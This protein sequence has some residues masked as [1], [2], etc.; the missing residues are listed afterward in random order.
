MRF[1]RKWLYYGWSVFEIVFRVR[2]WPEMLSLLLHRDTLGDMQVR[3]RQPRITLNIRGAMDLW[4]V[5]ETF[6]DAFYTRYGA[7]VQDGWTVVDIGAGV[8]D[9]SILSAYSHPNTKVFAYEPFPDSF[10]LLEK[11]LAQNGLKN[12]TAFQSAVWGEKGTLSLD[13]SGG[14][15]LQ[16]T[17]HDA[18]VQEEQGR[19]ISVQAVTL[20][21]ILGGQGIERIDL[22]KLDCEGAEYAI[23]MDVSKKVLDRIERIVM[24]VHDLDAERNHHVLF[25][26]LDDSGY[27]VKWHPNI[28]HDELGY[29]Y[30][31][32]VD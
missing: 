10:Q 6:L 29:L 14:E 25:S 18:E 27:R 17:S 8:G 13:L 28:V 30:A 24:E 1:L 11:N 3:L 9:F 7:A 32:R 5:K 12:V 22:L 16:L 23:L 4:A 2:N 31:S 19:M 20:E 21:D 26:F 15:P